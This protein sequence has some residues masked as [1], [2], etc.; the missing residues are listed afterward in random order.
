MNSLAKLADF[1]KIIV[2]SVNCFY[3]KP[4]LS[5]RNLPFPELSS[6]LI[7]DLYEVR[8]YDKLY[9]LVISGVTV[10]CQLTLRWKNRLKID[11]DND[12]NVFT[13]SAKAPDDNL[14]QAYLYLQHRNIVD[15]GP[16]SCR[17]TYKYEDYGIIVY[18]RRTQTVNFA[19]LSSKTARLAK[20]SVCIK[21]TPE[22]LL[23]ISGF[24]LGYW[25]YSRVKTVK[26]LPKNIDPKN[27]EFT[28]ELI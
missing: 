19:L 21:T 27:I 20:L 14:I 15:N 16:F 25:K 1:I 13:V 2:A 5:L 7:D 18:N 26:R 9:D 11:K 22:D 6:D 24:N 23:I 17:T 3:K 8:D 10:P 4:K 28:F 12:I